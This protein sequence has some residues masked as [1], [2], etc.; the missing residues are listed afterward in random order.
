MAE[1]LVSHQTTRLGSGR[2]DGPGEE[3]CVMELA[4]MLAG[5][6]FTDRPAAVCPIIAAILRAYNDEIDDR[7]RQALYRFAADSVG[8]RGE[9]ARQL[10]RARMA[11]AWARE[12]HEAARWWLK[13]ARGTPN[14]PHPDDGPDRI[15]AY[16]ITSIGRRGR[17]SDETHRD[18][19][20][21][22][23]RLIAMRVHDAQALVGEFVEHRSHAV[24]DGGCGE[25]LLIAELR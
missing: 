9:F 20:S 18:A 22:I 15:A 1:I 16:V 21:L 6:R 12:R 5:E 14:A 8:T 3:V 11:I 7:R 17:W 25:E 13:L 10:E 24:E 23:D 4:S 19:L 2:H